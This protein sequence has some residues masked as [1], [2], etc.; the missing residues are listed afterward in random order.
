MEKYKKKKNEGVNTEQ[1]DL[2]DNRDMAP[3]RCSNAQDV[4]DA[5]DSPIRAN[6][7]ARR[8]DVNQIFIYPL[9]TVIIFDM[10]ALVSR[11][12]IIAIAENRLI[13]NTSG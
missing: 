6:K 4:F 11:H 12:G 1:T 9:Q 3:R 2:Y 5:R 7:R 8:V 13:I 10:L